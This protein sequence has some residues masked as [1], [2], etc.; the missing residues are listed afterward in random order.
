MVMPPADRSGQHCPGDALKLLGDYTT[1]RVVDVLAA[2]GLRFTE[3]QRALGDTNAVTLTKRLKRMAEAGL[4]KR[5]ERALNRQS[6]MYEL[7]EKGRG[8]LPVLREIRKFATKHPTPGQP[9]ARPRR[10]L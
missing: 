1:L 9:P 6:V 4:L 7:S 8:L 5:T 2:T 10:P 3:L